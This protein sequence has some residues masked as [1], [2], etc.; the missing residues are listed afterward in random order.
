MNLSL[1]RLAALG[2]GLAALAL[3][4]TAAADT[5]TDSYTVPGTYT[6]A[7]PQYATSVSVIANGAGGTDATGGGSS[8]VNG[9]GGL[10]ALVNAT[11]PVGPGTR[12]ADGDP[13]EVIVGQRGGGGAGG[14]GNELG[15]HGGNGGGLALVADT[16][17]TPTGL[18]IAGGGGGGGGKGG[19]DGD[20]GGAG[21]QGPGRDAN[22]AAGTGLGHGS[23][24]DFGT[25]CAFVSRGGTGGDAG[26]ATD[27]GGGGGGGDGACG[28]N[29]G[30][31]GGAGGGGGGGGGAGASFMAPEAVGTV[32]LTGFNHDAAVTLTFTRR[33]VA[34]QITSAA[35]LSV[36]LSNGSVR[37]PVTAS[38]APASRFSIS[39]AP[40][41]LSIDAGTGV[42]SGTI[43][44][45]TNGRFT[46]TVSADN[47]VG[48][49]AT[50]QFT[51]DVTAPPVTVTPSPPL[52]GNVGLP[53]SGALAAHGGAGPIA[54]SV[55]S[56]HLPPGLVLTPS[57]QLAGAPTQTGSTTFTVRATDSAAPTA[58]SAS[59]PVTVIVAP[60]RLSVSTTSLPGIQVG[61][62]YE[63]SLTAAM[64]IGRLTWSL[65]SGSLPPGLSLIP[66]GKIVGTPTTAGTYAFT[67]EVTDGTGT[68]ATAKL[69]IVVNPTV[70]AAVYV[71]NGA[72]SGVH[73][74][75]LGVNGNIAPL[76]ALAGPST[77]LNGTTAVT[78]A[79]DGRTYVASVNNNAILAYPYGATGDVKPDATL[80]GPST[81]LASPQALTLG[82]DG[83]L[84]VAD[85]AS[86]SVTVY[87]P[88]ASGDA[89]PVATIGGPHT[90]L[91]SPSAVAVDAGGRV[92]VADSA[93][94]SLSEFAAGASGDVAPIDVIAGPATHLNGPQGLALDAQGNLLVA[95]TYDESIDEYQPSASGNVPPIRRLAGPF[96]G[97]SFP[98][99]IDVDASGNAYVS[100]QFGGVETFSFPA[101][102][103][104]TP[105]AKIEGPAT[106]L[107]APGRLAVAPPLSVRTAKL[108]AARAGRRYAATLRANLG[109]MPYRWRVSRG[110]LP[111]GL[112]LR[113]A[114]I[115]GRP[116]RA[117]TYRFTVRVADASH[118]AMTAVGRLKLVVR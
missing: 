47:G 40:S 44:P 101:T 51:L 63:Q 26:T 39:G 12:F 94:S 49:A 41:W 74:F 104:Q 18:V 2:F 80:A 111:R 21:G 87:A 95:D 85:S 110:A 34:P 84:Y 65:A 27:A 33:D 115:A 75:A 113:G 82:G 5:V 98:V 37:F 114:R 76:T 1:G 14:G 3:P 97:L 42:L 20:N 32:G 117:G 58:D 24:G 55:A 116:A 7:I 17:G 99:G 118:P 91:R 88:G 79:P 50:Q 92:W 81:G 83:R 8:G 19:I 68:A 72:N 100:N 43:P 45:F 90:G 96:T 105:F 4:A 53:L 22:G 78:I 102:G 13:L 107:A 38:G 109:T 59:E 71:V 66:A 77:Q 106:G 73:S 25:E 48:A 15:G 9:A 62:G 11:I 16:A 103:N 36:P 56:G 60:R 89:A 31:A 61:R 54:W 86:A 29:A 30:N 10:G 67:A 108:P 57:G 70:Q 112:R 23:G 46:F 35:S 28:G 69:S 6:L 64:S 52:R 93:A